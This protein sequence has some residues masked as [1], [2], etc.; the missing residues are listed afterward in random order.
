MCV[1]KACFFHVIDKLSHS[2]LVVLNS[3]HL[4][5]T[6]Y[7]VSAT[8]CQLVT[9]VT[10]SNHTYPLGSPQCYWECQHKL[11]NF[12]LEYVSILNIFLNHQIQILLYNSLCTTVSPQSLFRDSSLICRKPTKT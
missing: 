9:L 10:V 5:F 6:L 1:Q 2:V 8:C 7:S 3:L 11:H 12:C 4:S